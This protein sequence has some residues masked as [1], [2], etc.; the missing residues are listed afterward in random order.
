MQGET[1]FKEYPAP[2]SSDDCFTLPQPPAGFYFLD[3]LPL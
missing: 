2:K 1:V 3:L